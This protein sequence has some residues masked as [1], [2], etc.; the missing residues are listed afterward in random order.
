MGSPQGTQNRPKNVPGGLGGIPILAP[1]AVSLPNRSPGFQNV[2][3][4]RVFSSI[5]CIWDVFYQQ[6][7]CNLQD[8]M[9][10]A[11]V[12][13]AR[14]RSSSS[15]SSSSSLANQSSKNRSTKLQQH[16]KLARNLTRTCQNLSKTLTPA[17]DWLEPRGAAVLPPG[18]LQVNS[19]YPA[20]GAGVLLDHSGVFPVKC[21][22]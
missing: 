18:G 8:I 13:L 4:G 12:R 14:H 2:Y 11:T 17:A 3:F 6:Q 21:R 16:S 19:P 9:G 15:R 20:R 5:F 10:L 1:K 22:A 7:P